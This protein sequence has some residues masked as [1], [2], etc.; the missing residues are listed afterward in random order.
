MTRFC[1]LKQMWSKQCRWK[2]S[3]KHM[4]PTQDN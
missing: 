3:L 2:K 4:S 1:F